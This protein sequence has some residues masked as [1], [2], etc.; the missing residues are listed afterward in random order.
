M[1]DGSKNLD[2]NITLGKQNLSGVVGDDEPEVIGY[3]AMYTI[4]DALIPRQWLLQRADELGIPEYILPG[5]P[6]PH[7]AYSRGVKRLLDKRAVREREVD[8]FQA[9]L[10]MYNP[11]DANR[12]LQMVELRVYFPESETNTEGGE[13]V[14]HTLGFFDYDKETKS[15][16]AVQKLKKPGHDAD[17]KQRQRYQKLKPIWDDIVER[18]KDP[19]EGWFHKMKRHHTGQDL[20]NSVRSVINDYTNT[21]VPLR[22][23]GAVYFFPTQLADQLEAWNTLLTDINEQFKTG[24]KNS[25]MR[26]IPMVDG[27]QEM[28]WVEQRVRETLDK[29]VD[30]LL[31]EAFE[32]LDDEEETAETIAQEVMENISDSV[33]TAEQY[34][35]LLQAQLS[36]EEILEQRRANISDDKKEEI[37]E[38]VL[39]EHEADEAS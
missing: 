4:G 31:A 3:A 17:E 14:H 13:T 26:T 35:G 10:Q 21:V 28:E 37:V 15:V 25:E 32:A 5:E 29:K 24:G 38:R 22:S 27:E 20:R 12:Y 34:N 11:D 2:S 33:E 8:G 6:R 39:D 30:D 19:E 36:V 18:M 7:V 1:T 16:R 9:E 23:G